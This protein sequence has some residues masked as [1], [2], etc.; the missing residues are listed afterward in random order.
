MHVNS[1]ILD[2]ISNKFCHSYFKV[3]KFDIKNSKNTK[4]ETYPVTLSTKFVDYAV[5]IRDLEIFADDIWV[6]TYPKCGTTLAQEAIWQI[7]NNVPM[8]SS[9]LTLDSRFPFLE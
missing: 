2:G 1:E 5:E 8:N 4:F 6:I 9:G 3:A 7:C